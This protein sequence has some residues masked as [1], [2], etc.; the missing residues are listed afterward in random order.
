MA[1]GETGFEGRSTAHPRSR[2]DVAAIARAGVATDW[3][4]ITILVVLIALVVW[5]RASFD[6]WVSRVDILQAYLPYYSF[7]G[8]HLRHGHIPGWNP[9]QFAGAP[10]A[11]DPQSGWMQLPVMVLFSLF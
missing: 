3:A 4:A 2:R 11:A 9:H 6:M 8:E 10:F 1:G 7:L 5:N